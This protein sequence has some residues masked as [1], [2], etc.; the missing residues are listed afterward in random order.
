VLRLAILAL[1]VGLGGCLSAP[2]TTSVSGLAPEQAREL[3]GRW[4]GWLVT[5]RSFAAFDLDIAADGTFE[6]TSQW[7][8]ARGILLV[9]DGTLRFDGTGLWRGALRLVGHGPERS[10]WLERD[11][12]AVRGWLHPI[13]RDG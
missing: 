4:Q 6:V 3:M 10:L 12:R 13:R 11:D 9:T 1:A 2:A 8:S 7:T 5:E